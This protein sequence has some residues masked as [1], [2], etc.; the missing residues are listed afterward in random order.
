MFLNSESCARHSHIADRYE[1]QTKHQ[2][3]LIILHAVELSTKILAVHLK[4]LEGMIYM[5]SIS[6]QYRRAQIGK[7]FTPEYPYRTTHCW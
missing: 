1:L 7:W 6:Q 5:I 4:C 3:V 2:L